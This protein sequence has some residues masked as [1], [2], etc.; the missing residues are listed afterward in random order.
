MPRKGKCKAQMPCQGKGCKNPVYCENNANESGYC[1]AHEDMDVNHSLRHLRKH[2]GTGGGYHEPG[3]RT[4]WG[5]GSNWI[6]PKL[7]DR[8]VDWLGTET[9]FK[10]HGAD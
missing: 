4:H 1:A 9:T 2:K 8:R 7:D 3:V 6:V 10:P 5:D